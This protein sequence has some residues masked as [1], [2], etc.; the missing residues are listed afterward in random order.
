MAYLLDNK[1]NII[2]GEAITDADAA[3]IPT[4]I[5]QLQS[6]AP[7]Y[8]AER[9][10]K[11]IVLGIFAKCHMRLRVA[12]EPVAPDGYVVMTEEALRDLE[13]RCYREGQASHPA[14]VPAAADPSRVITFNYPEAR[15]ELGLPAVAVEA[16]TPANPLDLQCTCGHRGTLH[17][18]A[19]NGRIGTCTETDCPCDKYEVDEDIPF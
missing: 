18:G 7:E 11:A 16:P 3:L 8:L 4:L 9:V 10:V 12:P 2:E 17:N 6:D 1:G 15:A 13:A 19:R 5:K 14:P